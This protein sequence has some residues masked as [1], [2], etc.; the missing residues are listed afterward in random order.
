[1]KRASHYPN[2]YLNEENCNI[3][4]LQKAL[5]NNSKISG[6]TERLWILKARLHVRFFGDFFSFLRMRLNG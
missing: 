5:L 3:P 4:S 2:L 1:M 6:I